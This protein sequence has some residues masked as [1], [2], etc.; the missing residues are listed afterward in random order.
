MS[1]F[2][3]TY[4]GFFFRDNPPEG[5]TVKKVPAASLLFVLFIL[6]NG[7]AYFVIEYNKNR[8][9]DI[10]LNNHVRSLETNYHSFLYMTTQMA[11]TFYELTVSDKRVLEIMSQASKPTVS[12]AQKRMLRNELYTLVKNN[13]SIYKTDGV[14]LYNFVLPDNAMFLRVHKP[15]KFGDD[16]SPVR[17]DIKIANQTRKITRGFVQG[18]IAHGFRN[19]YPLFD[20]NNRFV[21]VVEISFSSESLQTQFNKVDKIHTHFLVNK[22]VFDS[23]MWSMKEWMIN[24]VKSAENKDYMFAILGKHNQNHSEKMIRTKEMLA[25]V[26]DEIDAKMH[27]SKTFALYVR[28]AENEIEIISFYPIKDMHGKKTLAWIVAYEK[29]DFIEVVLM[30]TM[31][32][33]VAVF[34]ILLLLFYLIY[35]LLYQKEILQREVSKQTKVLQQTN[36]ALQQSQAS[37]E[38]LNQSLVDK[39]NENV[40]ELRK[41]DSVMIQQ[42]RFAAMGEML[43]MIAHQWRQPISSISTAAINVSMKQELGELDEETV[44]KQMQFIQTQCHQMSVTINDFMDFFK[45]DRAKENFMLTACLETVEKMVAPQLHNR[46]ITLKLSIEDNLSLYG[47]KNEFDHV[48]LNLISN[49]KDALGKKEHEEKIISVQ[50]SKQQEM[51]KV[52]VSD[53]AGGIPE[54]IIEKIFDPYFTTKHSSQGTGIGLYMTRTIVERHFNGKI[55]VSNAKEGAEFIVELPLSQ[56]IQEGT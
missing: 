45:P 25:A 52:S 27:E 23:R 44:N 41:K 32:L 17:E 46:S 48:L 13:F 55:S 20:A 19:A 12:E 11:N 16:L 38:E 34:I 18:R 53:N 15:E 22:S 40:K 42:S 33:H 29:N 51:L 30:F 56:N 21:G 14:I 26:E 3:R 36:D 9:V 43:S 7:V 28:N 4:F 50:A 2:L 39:V 31:V 37:L 24:Y 47:V 49:A 54:E 6:V 35:Y 5:K 1:K 10:E 8:E